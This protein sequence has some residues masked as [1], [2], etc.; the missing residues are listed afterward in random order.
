MVDG[1]PGKKKI[2]LITGITG[3]D[4]FYLSKILKSKGFIVYGTTRN[5]KLK[6]K[7]FNQNNIK[8]FQT[9]YT[10]KSIK[11]IIIKL[12]PQYIFNLTGQ[13]YVSR[14]WDLL[15]DTLYSQGLIVSNILKAIIETNS[16]IRFLNMTSAE[17]FDH[18]I[19]QPFQE[20]SPL[21]PYNP[22]GCAQVLGHN[23]VQVYRETK[24][25]WASNSILFPHESERRPK[26]FL[27]KRIIED[28]KKIVAGKQ[29]NL[30]IG[31]LDVE[32]D[33]G[34]APVYMEGVIKQSLLKKPTD[35][36]F[37]T[38]ESFKVKDIIKKAFSNFDMNYKKYI[39]IDK[40]LVRNYEPSKIVGNYS[41]AKKL[42]NWKPKL[43]ALDIVD[44]MLKK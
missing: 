21:K 13:S 17:I 35:I 27:F 24:G 41:K 28:V 44:L 39:K 2:A 9:N 11:K 34:Y 20:T 7:N 18:S 15:Y 30:K 12:K 23:L 26:E 4:G 16:K 40:S 10:V 33:W 14:S 5:K 1:M 8:L 32:R 37:C 38:G 22:Y 3:Q 6:S 42:L 25:I 31:N 19:N 29:N 36:C 43:N